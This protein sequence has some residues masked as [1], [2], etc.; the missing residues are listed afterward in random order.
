VFDV[1]GLPTADSTTETAENENENNA[2]QSDE[3]TPGTDK[4]E[5]NPPTGDSSSIMLYG[6]LLVGSV[7]ML[8]VM[9]KF[10]SAHD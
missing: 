10:R 9:R 3:V 6:L 8:F 1:S 2:S 4:P 7:I 5:E